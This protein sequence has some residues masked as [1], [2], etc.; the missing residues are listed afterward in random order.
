M[1]DRSTVE[2]NV[3]SGRF[4]LLV[5]CGCFGTVAICAAVVWV[6]LPSA[7]L[8]NNPPPSPGAGIPLEI[9][10]VADYAAWLAR[11]QALLAGGNGRLPIADAM[12]KVL[13]RGTLEPAG[14]AP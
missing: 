8:Q 2:A 3:I 14:D 1:T 6:L 5:I 11:Q 9:T 7:R 12:A 10:P 13:K 4:V